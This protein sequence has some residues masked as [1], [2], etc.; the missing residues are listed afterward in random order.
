LERREIG[1]PDAHA[2]ELAEAGI[3]AVDRFAA[4][5]DGIDRSRARRDRRQ[6]GGI[7]PSVARPGVSVIVIR[8]SAPAGRA[9]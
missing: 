2:R 1:R 3:D 8:L 9:D 7:E 4:G 6:R 5:D